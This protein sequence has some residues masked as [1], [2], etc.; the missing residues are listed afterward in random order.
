MDLK[1]FKQGVGFGEFTEIHQRRYLCGKM[2]E[3]H[4]CSP[5]QEVYSPIYNERGKPYY[6]GT[7]PLMTA[8]EAEECLK[9]AETAWNGGLG[10]WSM[11]SHQKRI[12]AVRDFAVMMQERREKIVKT[13][14]WEICKTK[15]DAESEFDRTI[16]YINDSCDKL[17]EMAK[18]WE[19]AEK[20][21]FHKSAGLTIK[22]GRFPRGITLVMGPS[23]YPLNETFTTLIPALLMGNVVL[24]KP[25]KVGVLLLE[26]LLE[27]FESCF[28][29]GVVTTLYGDGGTVISPIVRSGK[30]AVFAFIGSSK[31]A[32][33][34][35]QQIP[36][37]HQTKQILGLGAKNPGIVLPGCDIE[38]AVKHNLKGT[39]S[40]NGQR[41]TA[42][43]VLFV[44]SS[45]CDKFISQFSV[46]V[47]KLQPGLPWD[48]NVGLTPVLPGTTGWFQDL[49]A[50]ATTRG[51][52][53]MN[54]GGGEVYG[55]Y[56]HPAVLYPVTPQM[57]LFRTEQFGPLVPIVPFESIHEVIKYMDTSQYGQQ[58]A[59]FAGENDRDNL[60]DFLDKARNLVCRINVN[61]S[62]QRGPDEIPFTG[63]KDSA[64]GTLDLTSALL[65]FSIEGVTAVPENDETY[66]VNFEKEY[67]KS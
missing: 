45:I 28:P 7:Y 66:F 14:M 17:E 46:E 44:H 4:L 32:D 20:S 57:Q 26:P 48:E 52:C 12:D 18:E 1:K 42:H 62:C 25:A 36:N 13:I 22:T 38:N 39:L 10:E 3:R 16:D 30:L 59:I 34:I 43:K 56:M 47:N 19:P 61:T 35:Y 49:L 58:V 60:K 65:E 21:D 67:K 40:Y 37:P 64:A 31:V 15:K 41:C 11:M 50:D 8:E 29:E 9:V 55:G 53:I 33:I 27:C 2:I 63:R 6:L 24:F 54:E 23:N 51:A 5:S